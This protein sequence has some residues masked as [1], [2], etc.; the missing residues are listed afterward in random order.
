MQIAVLFNP[1]TSPYNALWVHSIEEAVPSFSVS[2]F[3]VSVRSDEDVR[4]AFDT[5][6][7]KPGVGLIVPSDSN[8]VALGSS[9]HH[10]ASPA[11]LTTKWLVSLTGRFSRAIPI[12][13]STK[14]QRRQIL[15]RAV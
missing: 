11:S 2:T 1:Q 4:R 5:L 7:T 8:P 13:A 9:S 15:R 6:R 3:Q 10:I 14:R 12:P